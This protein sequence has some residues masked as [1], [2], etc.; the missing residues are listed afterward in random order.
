[1]HD[2]R[3]F[4]ANPNIFSKVLVVQIA[5]LAQMHMP[6]ELGVRNKLEVF[7]DC[8]DTEI[9]ALCGCQFNGVNRMNIRG[10]SSKATKIHTPNLSGTSDNIS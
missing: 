8:N 3:K 9:E 6:F 4:G 10:L 7:A 1:M 2:I 5:L